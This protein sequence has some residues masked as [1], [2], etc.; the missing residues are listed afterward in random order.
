MSYSILLE[1]FSANKKALVSLEY[2]NTET[3]QLT[4]VFEEQW[5]EEKTNSGTFTLQ[6]GTYEVTLH[7]KDE[8]GNVAQPYTVTVIV[9]SDTNLKLLEVS[10]NPILIKRDKETR[11]VSVTVENQS[12]SPKTTQVAWK[13]EGDQQWQEVKH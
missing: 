3:N 9:G 4:T 2:R 5:L 12:P 11:D 8:E 1:S 10:P 13:W 6:K 7:A